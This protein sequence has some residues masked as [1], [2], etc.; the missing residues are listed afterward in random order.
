[1]IPQYVPP[2]TSDLKSRFL[3][4]A[5]FPNRFENQNAITAQK[6]VKKKLEINIVLARA[7]KIDLVLLGAIVIHLKALW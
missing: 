4:L 5:S 7:R 3:K 1:M 6:N 2:R